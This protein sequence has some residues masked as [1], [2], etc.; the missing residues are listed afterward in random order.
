MTVCQRSTTHDL[1][2]EPLPNVPASVSNPRHNQIVQTVRIALSLDNRAISEQA[3]A[4]C[5][6]PPFCMRSIADLCNY[7]SAVS[8]W[9]M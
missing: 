2:V 9:F 6:F 8:K 7:A 1:V 5:L 3:E 4:T